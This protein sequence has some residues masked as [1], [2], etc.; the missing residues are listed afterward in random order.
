MFCVLS[1]TSLF[2]IIWKKKTKKKQGDHPLRVLILKFFAS[3]KDQ[4]H[5]QS[6]GDEY[7]SNV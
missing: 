6:I 5:L 7:S 3:L 2:I 1:V 4:L